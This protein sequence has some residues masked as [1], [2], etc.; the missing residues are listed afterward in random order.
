M[1]CQSSPLGELGRNPRCDMCDIRVWK[2]RPN[3]RGRVTHPVLGSLSCVLAD[4]A[5]ADVPG[6]LEDGRQGTR[7]LHVTHDRVVQLPKASRLLTGV[8]GRGLDGTA[9][10]RP[11]HGGVVRRRLGHRPSSV[12]RIHPPGHAC[13]DRTAMQV[14][15][16]CRMHE[17]E[18]ATVVGGEGAVAADRHVIVGRYDEP[19]FRPLF[20]PCPPVLVVL[21]YLPSLPLLPP[22]PRLPS[23]LRPSLLSAACLLP[24]RIAIAVS[25]VGDGGAHRHAA[26]CPLLP[27]RS[28]PR[29]QPPLCCRPCCPSAS[30]STRIPP[31][32]APSGLGTGVASHLP[33]TH[34]T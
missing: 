11:R 31:R 26:R 7:A 5:G 3:P 30:V 19:L 17:R 6:W 33:K 14:R 24:S 10:I 20:V 29:L 12:R 2:N 18:L 4:G 23:R 22:R 16:I 27:P 9:G 28:V 34:G 1:G 32:T 25:A 8:G 13:V 15:R 21:P